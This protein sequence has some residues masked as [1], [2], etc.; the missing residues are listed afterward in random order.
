VHIMTATTSLPPS[1]LSG[2]NLLAVPGVGGEGEQEFFFP[3]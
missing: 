2:S 3:G 1:N